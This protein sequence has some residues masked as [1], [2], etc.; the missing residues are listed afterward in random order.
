METPPPR[1]RPG[2]SGPGAPATDAGFGT[3]IAGRTSPRLG[4]WGYAFLVFFLLLAASTA[5]F[6]FQPVPLARGLDAKRS[7]LVALPGEA[8]EARIVVINVP[9]DGQVRA[10]PE[11]PEK[12]GGP[13]RVVIEWTAAP[14]QGAPAEGSERTFTV[15]LPRV[16]EVDVVDRR[17][18]VAEHMLLRLR[19]EPEK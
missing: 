12:P 5:Y 14:A 13:W 11:P 1:S 2:A 7:T 6:A 10:L 8:A 9:R 18:P 16:T 17:G 19:P 3:E 4:W 15:T